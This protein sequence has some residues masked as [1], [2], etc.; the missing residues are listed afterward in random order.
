MRRIILADISV[1]G[2]F[3][4]PI[5]FGLEDEEEDEEGLASVVEDGIS[6]SKASEISD[7]DSESSNSGSEA[8]ED[9]EDMNNKDEEKEN[10]DTATA[11]AVEDGISTSN[12]PEMSDADPVSSNS[13]NEADEDK[14]GQELQFI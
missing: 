4:T 5:T 8:E 12:A 2:I 6:T 13:G 9:K 7:T 10:R 14:E 11:P 3:S 1:N